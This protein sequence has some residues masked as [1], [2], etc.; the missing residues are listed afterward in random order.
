MTKQA[1]LLTNF[2]CFGFQFRRNWST[3]SPKLVCSML[4]IVCRKVFL[5]QFGKREE[6]YAVA[7][8]YEDILI[9][10]AVC[11]NLCLYLFDVSELAESAI[12][13]AELL[14]HQPHLAESFR[15]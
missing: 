2:A 13:L 11:G 7:A 5:Q 15:L 12:G 3:N 14:S 4:S 9:G 10:G 1:K 6:A 8:F